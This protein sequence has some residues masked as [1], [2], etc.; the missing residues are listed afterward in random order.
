MKKELI[1]SV[2]GYNPSILLSGEKQDKFLITKRQD[3]HTGCHIKD[4]LFSQWKRK[5]NNRRHTVLVESDLNFENVRIIRRFSDMVDVRLFSKPKNI[6]HITF[7]PT[8][9]TSCIKCTWNTHIANISYVTQSLPTSP[10]S[11]LTCPPV[12]NDMCTR[13]KGRNHAVFFSDNLDVIISDLFPNVTGILVNR[14]EKNKNELDPLHISDGIIGRVSQSNVHCKYR[15]S[16]S[17]P[18]TMLKDGILFGIGHI[19]R[20]RKWQA[21]TFGSAYTHFFY[22]FDSA[23]KQVRIGTEWCIRD[24]RGRCDDVQYV[25]GFAVKRKEIII[26]YGVNDCISMVSRINPRLF[27]TLM[28]SVF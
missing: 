2:Y 8:G 16:P 19:H 13:F 27:K 7:L 5:G 1:P 3:W 23:S 12:S 26:T 24:T 9:T 15:V 17:T 21:P 28:P 4:R 14:K 11:H 18:L 10:H 25:A 20:P 22:T 6:P